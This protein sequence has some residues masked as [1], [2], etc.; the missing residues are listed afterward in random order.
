M[1]YTCAYT[2][3]DIRVRFTVNPCGFG[4]VEFV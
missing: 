4:D 2:L 3:D 1:Y